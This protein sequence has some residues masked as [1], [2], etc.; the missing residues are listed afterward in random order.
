MILAVLRLV[1]MALALAICAPIHIIWK[2]VSGSGA[3]ARLFL[4][5]VGYILGLR[6]RRDGPAPPRRTLLL[7]NH[8][9]WLDIVVM[10]SATGCAFVSKAEV[11]GHPLIKWLADQRDTIY[12]E[13]EN[14]RSIDKQVAAVRASFNHPLPLAIFPEGTTNDGTALKP[15]RSALLKAVDPAPDDFWVIPVA[16]DYG[17]DAPLI[18]WY[19]GEPGVDN[20]RK[21]LTRRKPIRVTVHMLEPLPAGMNRK[22]MAETTQAR[23]A[24]KL[25]LGPAASSPMRAAQ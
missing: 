16:I 4:T 12:V 17:R 6:V 1:L 20:A 18:A 22:Q 23:I 8:V 2:A 11:R 7:P 25:G 19:D 5:I 9:S 15:F 13:R 21:I 14:K 24:D 3:I 10:A